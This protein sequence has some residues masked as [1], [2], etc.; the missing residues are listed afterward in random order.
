M[1][2]PFISA[3]GTK[4]SGQQARYRLC[5]SYFEGARDCRLLGKWQMRPAKA[6]TETYCCSFASEAGSPCV[7]PVT[8]LLN[9]SLRPCA[10]LYSPK[11][12]HT[13]SAGSEST[14]FQACSVSSFSED[15]EGSGASPQKIF[16]P[17]GAKGL[18]GVAI[19]LSISQCSN[20]WL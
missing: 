3:L 18:Q 14:G 13:E 5:D 12:A 1:F 15:L 11:P 4:P 16:C 8:L 20:K 17:F 9:S 7:R 6:F 10:Y 2:E 19:I